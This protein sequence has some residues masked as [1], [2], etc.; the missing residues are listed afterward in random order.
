MLI[1]T[2]ME[3]VI[4]CVGSGRRSEGPSRPA[5][6]YLC[7]AITILSRRGSITITIAARPIVSVCHG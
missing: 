5:S 7:A 1:H 4:M 6:L 2:E 3:L